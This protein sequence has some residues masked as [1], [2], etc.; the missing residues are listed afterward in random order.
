M[1]TQTKNCQNCKA[2]FQIEPEDFDFY[3]KIDVPA[4]T[5]CPECRL[6]RRLAWRNERSLH[7]RTCGLCN[8][9]IVATFSEESGITAYCN[10]C[11]WGDSWD[12]AS[13]AMEFDPKRPF[14][15][16]LFELMRKV[17]GVALFGLYPS[18]VNS[19]YTNMVGYLK[20]CYLLTHSDY[21]E[22]CLYGSTVTN[23]KNCIDDFF[24]DKCE[25]TY[26]SVNCRECY[27]TF[28]S[29]D[30]QSSYDIYF[31]R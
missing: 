1:E 6:Q 14:L 5:F 16:Q 24:I 26:E 31:S 27:R 7:K 11:W 29:M 30:C 28:F 9:S 17:P 18:L 12:A 10:P 20:N 15:D 19:E 23:S 21:D 3:K 8:K 2:D 13:Y 4:P 22:D 25:S